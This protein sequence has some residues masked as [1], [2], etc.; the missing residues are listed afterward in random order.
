M[1]GG[2]L[3]SREKPATTAA[4]AVGLNGEGDRSRRGKAMGGLWPAPP[5]RMVRQPSPRVAASACVVVFGSVSSGLVQ[6]AGVPV[7]TVWEVLRP[8]GRAAPSR[9]SERCV[10]ELGRQR[11]KGLVEELREGPLAGLG[12]PA[13]K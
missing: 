10:G 4:R 3:V 8:A 1:C 13:L 9:V 11:G 2:H 7:L 12:A 5:A 6:N